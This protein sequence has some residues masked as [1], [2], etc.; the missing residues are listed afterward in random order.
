MI[1]LIVQL[2][3]AFPKMGELLLAVRRE[4]VTELSK[5]RRNKH[6]TLIDEWVRDPKAK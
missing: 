5:R 2:L 3:I 1:T 4:Y 6:S